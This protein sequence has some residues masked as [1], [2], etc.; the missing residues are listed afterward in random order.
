ME[1]KGS[2]DE[3]KWEEYE[4]KK[5]MRESI[6]K[7]NEIDDER[8]RKKIIR[9]SFEKLKESKDYE[10]INIVRTF[11]WYYANFDNMG[12]IVYPE[13]PIEIDKSN[14]LCNYLENFID[15][16]KII[17]TGIIK[18]LGDDE[19]V[20]PFCEELIFTHYYTPEE[21]KRNKKWKNFEEDKLITT[22]DFFIKEIV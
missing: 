22:E 1:Y 12:E 3:N 11:A 18:A 4:R 8:E 16:A 7:L 5:I 10:K 6:K 13:I 21:I 20:D 15:T 14:Y 19:T 2:K 17:I 9:K